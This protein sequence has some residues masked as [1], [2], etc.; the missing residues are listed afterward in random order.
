METC[1]E[2]F[3]HCLPVGLDTQHLPAVIRYW[4][5]IALD[6][7]ITCLIILRI[8]VLIQSGIYCVYDDVEHWDT[9]LDAYSDRL[10]D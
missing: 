5:T 3:I 4:I 8:R 9:I 10:S 7:I 6:T 2:P 1:R